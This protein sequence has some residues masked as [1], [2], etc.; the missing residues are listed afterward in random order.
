MLSLHQVENPILINIKRLKIKHKQY[1]WKHESPWNYLLDHQTHPLVNLVHP[2]GIQYD[3]RVKS[4][5]LTSHHPDLVDPDD[6]LAYLPLTLDRLLDVGLLILR[7]TRVCWAE[8]STWCGLAELQNKPGWSLRSIIHN[9]W[10]KRCAK[11]NCHSIIITLSIKRDDVTDAANYLTYFL[12]RT[13]QIHAWAAGA[14]ALDT[15]ASKTHLSS[16]S[17]IFINKKKLSQ[18]WIS[19]C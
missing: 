13:V 3:D 16:S 15:S 9:G 19:N 12:N 10:S 8:L 14:G 4:I 6:V 2:E 17:L 11:F 18:L 5:I 7:S 1:V